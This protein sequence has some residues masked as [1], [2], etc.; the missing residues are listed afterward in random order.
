MA[1]K[2][3]P[4]AA[5]SRLLIDIPQESKR[6]LVQIEADEVRVISD[7]CRH[8]G[9][10]IH[11]CYAGEDQV[12]RCPWHDRKVLRLDDSDAVCATYH[13]RSGILCLINRFPQDVVW[14]TRVI[15]PDAPGSAV[16]VC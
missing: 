13:R 5:T 12:L 16:T 1:V 6:L 8:R 2:R 10:P 14:P 3:I 4:F 9:G 11:L 15:V 7:K